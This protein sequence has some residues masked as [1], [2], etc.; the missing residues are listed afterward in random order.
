RDYLGSEG[1]FF[2]RGGSIRVETDPPGGF[3]FNVD[4]E[5]IGCGPA[6]F[7]AIPRALDVIVGPGYVP[8]PL[9]RPPRP[10]GHLLGL[11]A[12]SNGRGS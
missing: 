11:A 9:E 12:D 1:A 3:E 4:G 8:D 7:S 5:L 2:A 6:D 10:S